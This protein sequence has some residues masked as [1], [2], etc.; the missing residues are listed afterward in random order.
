MTADAAEKRSNRSAML[1]VFIVVFIDLLGFFAI[2]LPLLPIIADIYIV[3]IVPPGEHAKFYEGMVLGLL[4]ASFS[5][6]QFIFAPI[7]G[8]V[9]DRMGGG[10]R[11]CCWGWAVRSHSTPCSDSPAR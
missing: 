8:R 5:L 4:M 7:W 9:S 10:G 6:M 11:S 1:I 3:E 2:V